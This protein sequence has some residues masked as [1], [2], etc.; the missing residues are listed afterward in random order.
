MTQ[1]FAPNT[2]TDKNTFIYLLQ[3]SNYNG[4]EWSANGPPRYTESIK[5]Y[6]DNL[7]ETLP[8]GTFGSRQTSPTITPCIKNNVHELGILGPTFISLVHWHDVE[9][10]FKTSNIH[11]NNRDVIS[12]IET[13]HSIGIHFYNKITYRYFGRKHEDPNLP[14]K[15]IFRENCPITYEEWYT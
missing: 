12:Q 15:K 9:K 3:V 8:V 11:N 4:T 10:F 7:N 1:W 14:F 5:K 6:C 2:G 13:S